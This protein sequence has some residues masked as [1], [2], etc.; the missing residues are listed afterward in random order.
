MMAIPDVISAVTVPVFGILVDRFGRRSTVLT[1]CGLL[2]GGVYLC[3]GV[4]GPSTLITT[5][6]AFLVLYGLANSTL[7]AVYPSVALL[8]PERSL[9]TA[10]GITTSLTN[11]GWVGTPI[12]VAMLTNFDP[13]FTLTMIFFAACNVIGAGLCT[14]LYLENFWRHDGILEQPEKQSI[15]I[16]I[17]P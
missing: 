10:V 1:L 15:R 14:W 16:E 3:L 12:L 4:L 7:I 11:L 17:S 5:P 8:V 9:A 13:T 6:I 2:M